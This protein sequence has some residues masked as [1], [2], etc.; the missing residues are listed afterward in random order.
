MESVIH[1][2]WFDGRLDGA[3]DGGRDN[4]LNYAFDV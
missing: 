2:C 4:G 1:N 3:F